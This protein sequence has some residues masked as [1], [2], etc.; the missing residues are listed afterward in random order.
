MWGNEFISSSYLSK[1]KKY[2][3]KKLKTVPICALLINK[4]RMQTT[5]HLA[6]LEVG[7]S[8]FRDKSNLSNP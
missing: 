4:T 7:A 8:Q 5:R 6:K 1:K 3:D 2:L